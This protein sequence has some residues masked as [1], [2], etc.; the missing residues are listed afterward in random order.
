M[1][2]KELGLIGNARARAGAL[3]LEARK[4]VAKENFEFSAAVAEMEQG[5][6]G[7][8]VFHDLYGNQYKDDELDMIAIGKKQPLRCY[9]G[10]KAGEWERESEK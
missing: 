6:T 1:N 5:A 2:K 8:A 10:N 3:P 7:K 4:P 9:V